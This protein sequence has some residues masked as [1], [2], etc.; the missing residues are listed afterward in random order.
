MDV[1]WTSPV[2]PEAVRFFVELRVLDAVRFSRGLERVR[3][4]EQR[5]CLSRRELRRWHGA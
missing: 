3:R 1:V 4:R 2:E 5:P